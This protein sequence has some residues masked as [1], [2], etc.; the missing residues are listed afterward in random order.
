L[1][2]LPALPSLPRSLDVFSNIERRFACD[3]S[4]IGGALTFALFVRHDLRTSA[5]HSANG[6]G[7]P[8]RS[9]INLMQLY[10]MELPVNEESI[11]NTKRWYA[12]RNC[13]IRCNLS[14][15]TL[16]LM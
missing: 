15:V 6:T 14:C 5:A 7:G 2:P 1:V 16:F 9:I 12:Y 10:L 13:D 8:E 3:R 11:W 4:R